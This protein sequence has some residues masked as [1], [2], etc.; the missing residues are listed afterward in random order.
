[1]DLD[2]T[3]LTSSSGLKVELRRGMTVNA[4][5]VLERRTLFSVLYG[6]LSDSLDPRSRTFLD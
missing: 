1:V 5:F 6:K 2:D 3:R 4:R